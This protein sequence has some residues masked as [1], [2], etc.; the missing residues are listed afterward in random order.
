MLKTS[1]IAAKVIVRLFFILLLI[2]LVPFMQGDNHKLQDLYFTTTHKWIF[3]FPCILILGFIAML[4]ICTIKKYK[5]ADINWL[6]VLNTTILLAYGA[7]LYIRVW[8][9]VK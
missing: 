9:L 8:H 2:S 6:L 3:I 5:E 1:Q 7:T 4:V